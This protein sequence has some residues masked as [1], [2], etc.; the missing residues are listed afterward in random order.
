MNGF[1]FFGIRFE[2][3]RH[4]PLGN[5]QCMEW[6]DGKFISNC[7]CEFVFSQDRQLGYLAEDAI[8]TFHIW[9]V[10]FSFLAFTSGIH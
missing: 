5:N 7:Q 3:V 6:P 9:F 1:A 8:V 10:A 4:V 2:N